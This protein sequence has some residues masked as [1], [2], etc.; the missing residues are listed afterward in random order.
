MSPSSTVRAAEAP[1]RRSSA[2]TVVTVAAT[3]PDALSS[4]R[5]LV[6]GTDP[7]AR[8]GARTLVGDWLNPGRVYALPVGGVVVTCDRYHSEWHLTMC[9]VT[10]DGLATVK[11]WRQKSPMGA[12]AA[13]YI[14]RRLPQG[15]AGMRAVAAQPETRKNLYPGRCRSCR[16]RVAAG[17]GRLIEIPGGYV[18]AH[19]PGQCPPPPEVVTPNR[20]G[21]PCWLCGLWV[22]P[23]T[24]VALRVG[25]PDP[26]TGSFYRAAHQTEPGACPAGAVPG[27]RNRV[28]GWCVGCG[29]LVA[30][31][32]GYWDPTAVHALRHAGECPAPRWDGPTWRV[33]RARREPV[34]AVGQVRRV[35]V[36]LRGGGDP[37]PPQTPGYRVLSETYIEFVGLVVEVAR[38]GRRQWARVCPA[39]GSEAAATVAE[40]AVAAVEARPDAGAFMAGWSAEKIGERAPWLAE[41]T[42]R[43]PDYDYRREF[44][45]PKRDYSRSNY[46][47]TRG[48]VFHWDLLPNRV[49]EA[50]RFTSRRTVCREFLKATPEGDVETISR[51]EV[52]AWLNHGPTWAAS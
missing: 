28:E 2:T 52:E 29:E 47:G 43:D 32:E 39:T 45:P 17:A 19:L 51:E 27:P 35:R 23:D 16:R 34:F 10:E 21:E 15:A 5:R 12:R 38:S 31:G 18:P 41:I 6:T 7:Q 26:V 37:V 22:E 8:P 30:A 24:G 1:A 33:R 44:Q 14:A 36:D 46:R 9:T 42:G 4:W 49:Y 48:V 13:S 40:D 50:F 11:E 3:P 25:E 20:R